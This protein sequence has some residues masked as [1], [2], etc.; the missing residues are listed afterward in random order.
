V[1]RRVERL[2]SGPEAAQSYA[3]LRR[4]RVAARTRQRFQEGIH[5]SRAS[6]ESKVA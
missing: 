6:P 3:T 2:S 1:S 5:T 4:C